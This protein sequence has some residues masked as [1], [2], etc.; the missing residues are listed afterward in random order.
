MIS[1]PRYETGI[2]WGDVYAP[3]KDITLDDSSTE[4]LCARTNLITYWRNL[5]QRK[6]FTNPGI[7]FSWI[8]WEFGIIVVNRPA[9]EKDAN[10]I[11]NSFLWCTG[12]SMLPVTLLSPGI[13]SMASINE[14]SWLVTRHVD[15]VISGQYDELSTYVADKIITWI[16][17]IKWWHSNG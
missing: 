3:F 17:F 4:Y 12:E 6:N 11:P 16:K 1:I 8:T 7:L 5:F 13:Y 2:N 9:S 15:L 14:R 10:K